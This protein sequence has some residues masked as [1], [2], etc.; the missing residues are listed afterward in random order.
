MQNVRF[1]V[2]GT[3]HWARTVHARTLVNL[4]GASLAGVWGRTP[5]NARAVANEMGVRAFSSFDELLDNVDAVSIAVAPQVQS[6]LAIR[7]ATAGKSLLLEKP[8]AA[9]LVD[10]EAVEAA[11]RHAGV[12]AI[13]FFMRRFVSEIESTVSRAAGLGWTGAYVKVHSDVMKGTGPY[14]G[15]I[16]RQ[17]PGAALWDIGP[18]V[19]SILLPVL[20]PVVRISAVHEGQCTELTIVHRDGARARASLTLHNEPGQ[21]AREYRF[22]SGAEQLV[23]PDPAFSQQ[24][25]FATAANDLIEMHRN[26]TRVH[27]CDA[28]FGLEVSR[29]LAAADDSATE[30]SQ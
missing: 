22:I 14:S 2:V 30:G 5:E 26:G 10:A 19:L 20:G 17:E 27:R 21:V 7:A 6:E 16:W 3:S 9:S 13:V 12:P 11:I 15:S 1:G 28:A 23:L 4:P 18:H 25:A 29:L 8:L 24:Q